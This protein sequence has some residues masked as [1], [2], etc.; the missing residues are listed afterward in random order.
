MRRGLIARAATG[1][2]AAAIAVAGLVP[3]ATTA[4]AAGQSISGV[5]TLPGAFEAAAL[6]AVTVRYAPEGSQSYVSADVAE[7]GAFSITGLAPGRYHVCA[8]T[9]AYFTADGGLE[10]PYNVLNACFATTD[11]FGTRGTLDVTGGSL[12]GQTL[13]L[14]WG[15]TISGT[16][17]LP[18]DAEPDWLRGV[19][20]SAW[21]YLPDRAGYVGNS[22]WVDPDTGRFVIHTLYPGEYPVNLRVQDYVDPAT[23]ARV[24]PGIEPLILPGTVDVRGA[25]V[26]G[27]AATLRARSLAGRFTTIPEAELTGQPVVGGTLAATTRA[28]TPAATS[29][30]YRWVRDGSTIPGATASTY[31]VQPD[32]LGSGIR[33]VV[34]GSAPGLTSTESSTTTIYI[35]NTFTTVG[36]PTVSGTPRPG[37]TLTCATGTWAPA[38]TGFGY[39]WRRGSRTVS[40]GAPTYKVQTSDE[41]QQLRCYVNA[42]RGDHPS[43]PAASAPLTVLRSFASAGTVAVAGTPDLGATLTASVTGT[44]PAPGEVAYRWYRNGTAIAGATQAAYTV[45]QADSLATLTARAVVGRRGFVD[46]TATAAQVVVPGF[47]SATPA[48]RVTGDGRPGETLTA[49]VP[50]WT[51]AAS[52]DLQWL[53]DGVAIPGATSSSYR[54]TGS[55][56]GA[57]VSLRVVGSRTSFSSRTLTSNGVDVLR[58]FTTAPVPTVSGS[59]ATGGTLTVDPGAWSPTPGGLD[60]QWLR[61]GAEIPG[62]DGTSYVVAESDGGAAVVARVTARRAGYVPATRESVPVVVPLRQFVTAPTP[63]V[64][65][66]PRA[67]QRLTAKRGTWAAAPDAYRYQWFR[68]GSAIPGATASTYLLT[69]ADQGRKIS[70]SVTGTRAGYRTVTRHSAKTTVLREFTAA[71]TPTISGTAQVGRTLVAK[72]GAWSPA[73]TAFAYQ[74]FRDG[75]AISGATG[76]RYV[77]RAADRGHKLTVTVT[78]TRDGYVTLVR[79]SAAVVPR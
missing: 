74:W 77:V 37:Q 60:V 50:A 10:K 72:P 56:E 30:T 23:G 45:T 14:P 64:V 28:W 79:R 78:A 66:T 61:D 55:D 9:S 8:Y 18:S 58:T 24:V 69:T 25:D 31:T 27:V 67:G 76:Q 46:A 71:P 41:G 11:Y 5:V 32:D 51:P 42:L 44:S 22:V 49:T 70:V 73:P 16:V 33:A 53:R 52:L 6:D 4:S 15:R 19:E 39:E 1:V 29:Y 34:A 65:G 40:A 59:T 36:V 12:T 38:P 3:A 26:T 62:A 43:V 48:P 35:R 21:R 63:T 13:A 54:L 17:H 68:N 47:F 57:T 75:Q 2:L 20:A 7:D